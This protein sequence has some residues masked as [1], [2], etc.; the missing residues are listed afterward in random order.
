MQAWR[1][2]EPPPPAPGEALELESAQVGLTVCFI[3]DE[4]EAVFVAMQ[5]GCW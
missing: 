3:G 1:L 2:R 4:T 5:P